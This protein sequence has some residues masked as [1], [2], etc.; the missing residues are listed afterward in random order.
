MILSSVLITVAVGF[1]QGFVG[2]ATTVT[3]ARPFAALITAHAR[4][5][6]AFSDSKLRPRVFGWIALGI[7]FFALFVM[8]IVVI[9][10]ILGVLSGN[11]RTAR[12][13]LGRLWMFSLIA[14][15][16]LVRWLPVLESR[17]RRAVAKL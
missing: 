6:H 4:S 8:H 3:L 15:M 9:E 5:E 2:I 16:A 7:A 12:A 11:N 14:G 13:E 17:I 1:V 10:V